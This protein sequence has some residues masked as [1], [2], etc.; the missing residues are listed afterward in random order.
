MAY[1]HARWH[2]AHPTDYWSEAI[3]CRDTYP[4]AE[5]MPEMKIFQPQELANFYPTAESLGLVLP[6]ELDLQTEEWAVH[7]ERVGRSYTLAFIASITQ[8][9]PS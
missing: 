9:H 8:I 7:R 3:D 1:S 2:A 5:S 6:A 4:Y